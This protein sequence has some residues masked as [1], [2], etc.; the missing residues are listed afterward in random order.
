MKKTSLTL[1]LLSLAAATGVAACR[2]P[3]PS[4]IEEKPARPSP[5]DTAPVAPPEPQPEKP[6]PSPRMELPVVNPPPVSWITVEQEREGSPGGYATGSFD[7]SQNKITVVTKDVQRFLLD[8]GAIDVDWSRPVVLNIDR[9]TY[10]L[11]RRKNPAI[12]FDRNPHGE[13]QVL[14]P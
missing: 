10:E 12:L 11:R 2:K 4:P 7:S 9:K 6:K 5:H 3:T 1:G 13:W 8:T 14:E